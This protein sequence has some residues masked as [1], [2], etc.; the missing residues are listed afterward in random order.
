MHEQMSKLDKKQYM[1]IISLLRFKNARRLVY[2]KK[3]A[4]SLHYISRLIDWTFYL[5][6]YYLCTVQRISPFN[7]LRIWYKR[8]AE[9]FGR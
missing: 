5:L 1:N 2:W 3:Y 4:F 9:H 8:D 6:F 7:H